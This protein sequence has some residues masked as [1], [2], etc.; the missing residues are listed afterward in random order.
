M[1]PLIPKH[2]AGNKIIVGYAGVDNTKYEELK[3]GYLVI[4]KNPQNE[5]SIHRLGQKSYKGWF[6]Y[7]TANH[8]EDKYLVTEENFIGK[9]ALINL[10]FWKR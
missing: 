6:A 1:E 2:P 8:K 4:Y 9:V 10:V 3:P 7:G 5:Y